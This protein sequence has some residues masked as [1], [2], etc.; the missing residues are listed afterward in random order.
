MKAGWKRVWVIALGLGLL[1]VLS[2]I[3]LARLIELVK[4][5]Y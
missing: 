1:A 2:G 5:G 4:G 3:G